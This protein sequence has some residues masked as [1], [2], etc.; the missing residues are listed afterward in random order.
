M[1]Y[2]ISKAM[3]NLRMQEMQYFTL[4]NAGINSSKASESGHSIAGIL[5]PYILNSKF[6]VVGTVNYADY[7]K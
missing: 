1:E 5:L 6:P 7:K 3:R 2:L 4:I